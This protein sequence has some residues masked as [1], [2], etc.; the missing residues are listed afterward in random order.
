M[1]PREHLE[2][3]RLLIEKLKDKARANIFVPATTRLLGEVKNRIQLDGENTSG[4]QIG[5][6]STEPMYATREQFDRGSSFKPQGKKQVVNNGQRTKKTKGPDRKS[7]YLPG[8]YKE[9]RNIQGKPIDK[10][11][12]TYRGDL[13]NSYQQTVKE[14]EIVQGLVSEKESLK[15]QG[16]EKKYGSVLKPQKEEIQRYQKAVIELEKLE[17]QKI[18]A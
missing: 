14:N 16:L 11:N 6:Y 17:L 9:L 4:G 3:T 2:R 18:N 12:L 13:M 10:V 1:T 8:G 7:M 15:R 5:Q